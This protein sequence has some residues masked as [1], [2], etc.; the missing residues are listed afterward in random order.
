MFSQSGYAQTASIKSSKTTI[1]NNVGTIS[2]KTSDGINNFEI[3]YQGKIAVTD[4]DKAIKSIS[5]GG[6]LEIKKTTFGSKREIYI[7]SDGSGNLT[8]KYYE[9]RKQ[10]SYLPAGKEW[11]AEILPDIVRSTRIAAESRVNRYYKK[12]GVDAVLNEIS[13]LKGDYV[14]VHYADLLLKRKGL[15]DHELED[16]VLRIADE[17]D[18]DYYLATLLK[19]KSELFLRN[20]DTMDAYFKGLAEIGSDYYLAVVLKNAVKQ[21]KPGSSSMQS[22]L[23]AVAKINSD[24]YQTVVVSTLLEDDELSGENLAALIKITQNIGSDYYQSTVLKKALEHKNLSEESF[25]RLIEEVSNVSSD[26]YMASIFGDLLSK[27]LDT[28]MKVH[29]INKVSSEINSDYYLASVLSEILKTD[30]VDEAVAEAILNAVQYVNSDHYASTVIIKAS[31]K[32]NLNKKSLISLIKATKSI[33]SDYYQMA[34]LTSLAEKVNDLDDND[35]KDAYMD[36]AKSISSDT[37]FGKAIKA[38]R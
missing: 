26:Y 17:V 6:F 7:E 30:E 4:D 35:V 25:D 15:D 5:S 38:L 28:R 2:Y 37:Y 10:I 33:N 34:A 19:N 1:K 9:G 16:I 36:A 32:N 31:K 8:K 29:I 13:R 11:L 20:E 22:L 14:K 3:E 23:E 21:A 24:Y 27:D 18:S 12:G